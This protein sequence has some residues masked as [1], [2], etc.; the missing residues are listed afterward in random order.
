[1]ALDVH[2]ALC[3]SASR[4]FGPQ[5]SLLDVNA[6]TEFMFVTVYEEDHAIVPSFESPEF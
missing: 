1:M 4:I 3:N 6:D 5:L 2:N